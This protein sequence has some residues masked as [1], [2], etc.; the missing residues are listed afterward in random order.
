MAGS[1][2]QLGLRLVEKV[3]WWSLALW[4]AAL[5]GAL[6]IGAP[7]ALGLALGGGIML[8]FLALH[9]SLAR[10]WGRPKRRWSAR[11]YLWFLWLVKW[12]V[13][14]TA[15]WFSLNSGQASPVW[16]CVGATLVPVVATLIAVRALAIASSEGAAHAGA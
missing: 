13:V 4:S 3:G 12:P 9:L 16:V 5:I 1:R 6:R 14:G 10:L 15:L 7:A 2:A 8:G 11:A